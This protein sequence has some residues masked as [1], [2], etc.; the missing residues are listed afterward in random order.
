MKGSRPI[1]FAVDQDTTPDPLETL[2]YFE[3]VNS[4]LGV[5]RT[6]AYGGYSTI[7]ALFN[8]KR[9]L[10]VGR[11][12]MSNGRWMLEHSSSS[13]RMVRYTTS[14]ARWLKTLA[15]GRPASTR[16]L[17]RQTHTRS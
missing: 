17:P 1:Y 10:G 12:R 13:T 8:A 3:G 14:T 4:V 9:S 5:A 15:S 7:N 2:P 11:L 6:G 16:H